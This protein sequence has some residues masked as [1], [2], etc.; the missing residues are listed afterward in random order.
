MRKNA[1]SLELLR[2]AQ[3]PRNGGGGGAPPH[4]KRWGPGAIGKSWPAGPR[5]R[6]AAGAAVLLAYFLLL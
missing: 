6:K 2:G 3:T 1:V 4:K 5:G